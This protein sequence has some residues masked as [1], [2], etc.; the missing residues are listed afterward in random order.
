MGTKPK[1]LLIILAYKYR[2]YVQAVLFS[3]VID[4][5]PRSSEIQLHFSDLIISGFIVSSFIYFL[6]T[7]GLSELSYLKLR[8]QRMRTPR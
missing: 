7:L 3:I 2:V 1:R 4:G 8:I 6:T 5:M